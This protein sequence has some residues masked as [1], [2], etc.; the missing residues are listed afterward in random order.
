MR[1]VEARLNVLYPKEIEILGSWAESDHDISALRSYRWG[2]ADNSCRRRSDAI[3]LF[4]VANLKILS[5]G[6]CECTVICHV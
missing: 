5:F 4:L 1:C 2:N 3:L 6:I